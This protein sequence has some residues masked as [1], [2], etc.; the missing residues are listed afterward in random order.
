MRKRG[1]AAERDCW[2]GEVAN[3]VLALNSPLTPNALPVCVFCRKEI[4]DALKKGQHVVV[5]RYAYSGVAFSSGEGSQAI[6][7]GGDGSQGCCSHTVSCLHSSPSRPH[8]AAKKGMDQDWC[9]APDAG[10]PMPDII[11]YM[12]LSAEA[13]A[14]R[15]GYGAER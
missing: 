7:G 5:D 14:A 13:A 9:K 11:F 6:G 10:L 4:E 1:A 3:L 2:R 12:N 15:G 8:C